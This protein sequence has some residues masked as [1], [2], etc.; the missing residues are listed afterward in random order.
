MAALGWVAGTICLVGFA[1]L[2]CFLTYLLSRATTAKRRNRT[3]YEAVEAVLGKKHAM[4]V[5]AVQCVYLFTS[6]IAYIIVP[7]LSIQTIVRELSGNSYRPW[8][9]AIIVGIVQIPCVI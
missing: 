7:A 1:V 3:Y 4:G 5:T 9:F 2:V 8:I 6:N